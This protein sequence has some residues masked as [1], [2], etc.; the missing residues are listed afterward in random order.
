MCRRKLLYVDGHLLL[1]A[2]HHLIDMIF[3]LPI[4]AA[5][6]T[7]E[8]NALNQAIFMVTLFQLFN[9]MFVFPSKRLVSGKV[10]INV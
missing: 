7:A 3:D 10:V 1:P 5:R 8:A 4:E 2:G 6:A 9:G